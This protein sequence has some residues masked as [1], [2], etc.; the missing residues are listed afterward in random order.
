MLALQSNL[1]RDFFKA[2]AES[3]KNLKDKTA[4]SS[5]LV[6]KNRIRSAL[7]RELLSNNSLCVGQ[8]KAD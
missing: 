6:C 4:F 7:V 2:D 8:L 5:F 1:R 3:L